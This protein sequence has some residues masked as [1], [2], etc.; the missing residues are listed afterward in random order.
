MSG[1]AWSSPYIHNNFRARSGQIAV[2][3]WTSV[4]QLGVVGPRYGVKLI[5]DI[6]VKTDD[7]WGKPQ[8]LLFRGTKS[9]ILCSTTVVGLGFPSLFFLPPPS[10]VLPKFNPS[11]SGNEFKCIFALAELC[12]VCF[13]QELTFQRCRQGAM[14]LELIA[15]ICS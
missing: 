11:N 12:N 15:S 13:M 2:D 7:F 8:L 1:L 3:F 9:A 14:Y 5:T 10:I 6:E 4:C